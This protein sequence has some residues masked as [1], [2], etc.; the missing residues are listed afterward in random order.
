MFVIT[1]K[2]PSVGPFEYNPQD[3]WLTFSPDI[4]DATDLVTG[5][6]FNCTLKTNLDFTLQGTFMADPSTDEVYLFLFPPQVD[7]VDN[8]TTVTNPPD[9][10]K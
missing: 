2:E 8:L 4:I 6:S 7:V 1:S 10:E 5:I 9:T 3:Q